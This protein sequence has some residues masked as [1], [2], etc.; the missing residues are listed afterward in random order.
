MKSGLLQ[1]S[2]EDRRLV[3]DPRTKLFMLITMAIFV[4]GGAAADVLPFVAPV[5]CVM[6]VCYLLID[7]QYYA[8]TTYVALYGSLY[9]INGWIVPG[10]TGNAH[11]ILY[12]LTVFIIRFLPG[13]M[14][15]RYVFSSTTVSE[16]MAAMERMRVSNKITIPMSVMFRFIPTV[17][18]EFSSINTAMKMRD[19]RI[20]GKNAAKIVEYRFVPLMTCCVKIGNEL[21]AAALARGLGGGIKRTNICKIGFTGFDILMFAI[22]GIP[23]IGLILSALGILS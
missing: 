12:I 3:L 6:P 16:F 4:L 10:L 5:L 20:G 9:F 15:A 1:A 11:Y 17:L 18:E 14:M 2:I 13:I 23:Y 19:I 22:C 7:R 8:L 21:S